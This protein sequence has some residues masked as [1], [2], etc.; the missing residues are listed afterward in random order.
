[1]LP[2]HRKLRDC[3]TEQ[4]SH[5]LSWQW[6][7]APN[8]TCRPRYV[9]RISSYFQWCKLQAILL[10][11]SC[12]LFQFHIS[13]SF[14]WQNRKFSMKLYHVK[15]KVILPVTHTHTHTQPF[16]C[17]AGICPGLPGWAGTRKVKPERVNQSGFTGARDSEWQWHLLGYMQVCTSSQTTTPTSHLSVFYRADALPAAQPTASKHWRS[18]YYR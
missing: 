3:E 6:N 9:M 1:M 5:R 14:N 18:L 17:S 13:Y 11:L 15:E 2:V 4:K 10:P 12:P 16:Y 8:G 7:Y